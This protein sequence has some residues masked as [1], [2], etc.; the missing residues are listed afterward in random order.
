MRTYEKIETLYERS[1][2]GSKQ[3]IDGKWRNSTVEFLK[4][5]TWVWT[6]KVDGTNIRVYWD[7]HTIS[8]GGRTER[9]SIPAPLV[10]RLNE[11]F[12]GETNAQVFE[13]AFGER[14]VI[15]YGE[16]YGNGIQNPAGK[17]Y[18]PDGVDF[19]LFDLYVGGNYQSRDAVEGIARMFSI[20]AVPVVGVGTLAEAEEYVR[21]Q[22]KSMLGECL[23]E[24]IVAR[25]FVELHD[26]T[27]ERLIVKIKRRDFAPKE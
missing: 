16:G 3:L 5:C 25:P 20:Q 6:E 18:K 21:S 19:I 7:G 9:A 2:D 1:T 17:A 4:D 15:L 14:E 12:G 27:G 11:L 10:N 22:P 13:Q 26:R 8:F 24:G 23:M